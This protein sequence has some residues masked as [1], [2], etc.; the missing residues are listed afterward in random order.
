MY[1]HSQQLFHSFLL[2]VEHDTHVHGVGITEGG[3]ELPMDIINARLH[4]L[5][6][7]QALN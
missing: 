7:H 6:R 4:P 5:A 3:C 2:C 1:C